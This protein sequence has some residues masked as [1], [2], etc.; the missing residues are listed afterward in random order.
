MHTHTEGTHTCA[1]ARTHKVLTQC[2]YNTHLELYRLSDTSSKLQAPASHSASLA[3]YWHTAHAKIHTCLLVMG[4]C[5]SGLTVSLHAHEAVCVERD[6]TFVKTCTA[7]CSGRLKRFCV[8]LVWLDSRSLA[9]ARSL[10]RSLFSFFSLCASTHLP[11]HTHTH[12]RR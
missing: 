9:L 7:I 12:V 4:F 2:I 6:M 5:E 8:R 3:M 10:A 1:R 11:M